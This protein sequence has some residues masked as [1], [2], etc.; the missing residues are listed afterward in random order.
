MFRITGERDQVDSGMNVDLPAADISSRF[1][2]LFD[3]LSV[4]RGPPIVAW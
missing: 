2:P 3:D 4:A 1:G